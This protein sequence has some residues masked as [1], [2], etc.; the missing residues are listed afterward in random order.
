ML[1]GHS[2]KVI[3]SACDFFNSNTKVVMEEELFLPYRT[4]EGTDDKDVSRSSS[5]C[6]KRAKLELEKIMSCKKGFTSINIINIYF[7]TEY[8]E[9][10]NQ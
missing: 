3:F 4:E 6:Y 9:I 2:F 8:E 7:L 10:L 1:K 5:T